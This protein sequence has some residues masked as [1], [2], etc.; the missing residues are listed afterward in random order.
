M[1]M[2][3]LLIMILISQENPLILLPKVPKE[4]GWVRTRRLFVRYCSNRR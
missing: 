2:I 3:M 4:K 1:L